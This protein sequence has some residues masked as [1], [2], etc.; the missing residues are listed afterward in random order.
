[1][2]AEKKETIHLIVSDEENP[3]IEHKHGANAKV[4]SVSLVDPKLA[5]SHVTAARLCGGTSTCLA[6][7]EV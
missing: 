6:L 7:H 4:V 5:K 3:K 1:M 2:A